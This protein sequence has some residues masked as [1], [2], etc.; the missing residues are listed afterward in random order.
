MM[1]EPIKAP[2]ECYGLSHDKSQAICQTCPHATGCLELMGTRAGRIQVNAAK[3]SLIPDEIV[4]RT[5]EPNA[6]YR[7]IEA[8]YIECWHQVFEGQP[9]DSVGGFREKVFRLAKVAQV[10]VPLFVMVNMFAHSKTHPDHYFS[11]GKLVDGRAI[12]RVQ[13]Y[14]DVCLEHFG[15]LSPHLLD[16]VTGSDLDDYSLEKRMLDSENKAGRWIIDYKLW[17]PGLPYD[18]M[19]AELENELDPYWLATEKY[20]E[21]TLKTYSTRQVF[22]DEHD[23]RH[24]ALTVY[25]LMKKRKHHA[26]S[27][28]RT[29]EK[30]M[31]KAVFEVL[32]GLG[33]EPSDFEIP[34]KP[35]NDPLQFWNRL[36]LAIQHLECLLL[37]NYGEGIYA[38]NVTSS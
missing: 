23:T 17:H 13:T 29:R 8:I 34:D 26:I 10:S 15:T 21:A 9:K 12:T 25:H 28:F 33:Y 7:D 5:E 1:L 24:Q 35:V 30:I 37:I 19:L 36:G 11:A 20:Y 38:R 31:P 3:F 32:T 14:R 18:P 16:V 6:D 4:R 22:R 27:N 2:L